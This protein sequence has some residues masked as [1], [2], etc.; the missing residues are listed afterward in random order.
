M[1]PTTRLAGTKGGPLAIIETK[2]P[3][4][5]EALLA[6]VG[7]FD[8]KQM[9]K[10]FMSGKAG[11]P[12]FMNNAAALAGRY[13][14]PLAG[15]AL[16]ASALGAAGEFDGEGLGTDTSQATGRFLADLA[17]TGGLAA[18]GTAIAPGVGTVALPLVGSLLG[19]QSGAGQAGASLGENIYNA[20][21]GQ[22][23][24]DK[25]REEEAKNI[26]QQTQLAIER[27]SQMAPLQEK[28]AQMADARAV[29]MAR[30]NM[31]IQRDYNF[32]N[33]LNDATLM[34]QQNFANQILAATQTAY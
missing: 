20:I 1:A 10:A 13:K 34:N 17:T 4:L 19:V 9:G 14:V 25:A 26:R 11:S 5:L 33:T 8:R 31:E 22:S 27:I 7:G 32:G 24:E 23:P 15:T 6:Q 30:R 18:I 16:L 12:G 28:M 21:T 2:E 3:S 29:N